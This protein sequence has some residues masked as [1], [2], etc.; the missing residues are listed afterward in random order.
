MTELTSPVG[1]LPRLH[2]V[3]ILWVNLLRLET[4]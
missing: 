2:H 4:I 1:V 3:G